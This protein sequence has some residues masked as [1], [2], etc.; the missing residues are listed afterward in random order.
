[1]PSK[2]P[3]AQKKDD[4]VSL[5]RRLAAIIESSDDA[6]IAKDLSGRVTDW[7]RSAERI[8]GYSA[9]EMIGQPVKILISPD[10]EDEEEKILRRIRR[11]ERVEPYETVRRHKDGRLIHVTLT[12]S[13]IK[14]ARGRVVGASK[15]ARD[16]TE[17]KLAE[18][19]LLTLIGELKDVR[20]ALDEHS[21]V[22]ITDAAGR[23]TF[24]N[25]KFCAISQY[26][27]AEL[28]GQDHRIINSRHHPKAFFRDLWGTI[29]RGR[30]WHGEIKNRAKDGSYYWVE[31]TIFPFL[32][33]AGKPAQ[34]V[35]IRTDITQRKADQA[36]LLEISEKER[37]RI[38]EDLHDGLG[39]QL[40]AIEIL[41]AGLKEDVAADPR[42]AKQ[43]ERIGRLLRES[44]GQVRSLARGL[45]PV[46][47][48]PDALWASLIE[49][50][51][52]ANV[53]GRL[54]CRLDCPVMVPVEDNQV[55]GHLFRI[56]QEAVNNALKHSRAK[57]IVLTLTRG[58]GGLEL[59]VTDNG[60]GFL[61]ARGRGLGLQVMHHRASVIGA[62]LTVDTKPGRGTTIRCR[63]P[64][65]K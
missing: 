1:M 10:R 48:D 57:Q 62:E 13:P 3:A 26:S 17:R 44:I 51:E 52:R 12:V 11:G 4:L 46:Q 38:G 7:N 41:C 5:Q 40:T 27:R 50:A 31:T 18:Q 60:R 24:V 54:E 37:H 29:G 35:A 19:K 55:A 33:A 61:P 16:T 47:D 34:Y 2:P 9:A 22:A 15:I 20:A 63:L 65:I 58:P 21:I 25:D 6:I 59:G 32:N 30:V 45:V 28:I 43:A 8:F 36:L 14:D 39:Q 64:G 49:L 56:A 42:L 23:I 53:P